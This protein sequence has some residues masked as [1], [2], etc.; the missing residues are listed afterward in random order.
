MGMVELIRRIIVVAF[1]PGSD[2]RPLLSCLKPG[3]IRSRA[4]SRSTVP[5]GLLIVLILRLRILLVRLNRIT[6]SAARSV[7]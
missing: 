4:R 1:R 3:R 6:C 7:F 5:C 2:V